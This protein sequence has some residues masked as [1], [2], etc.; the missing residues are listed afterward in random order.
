MKDDYF[1]IERKSRRL[2]LLLLGCAA[3]VGVLLAVTYFSSGSSDTESLSLEESEFK[4]WMAQH[5]KAYK[6]AEEF[7]HRFKIFKDNM[8][9]IHV[10]NRQ[11]N[12]YTLGATEF[13]D[14]NH[15]E[16][17][18]LMSRPLPQRLSRPSRSPTAAVIAESVDWRE[19]G[20]VTPVKNQKSCGSCW[21]F[22]TTG[23]VEGAHFIKTGE[24]VSL[25][26]QQLIDCSKD[27]GND[28]CG[29]GLM[30]YGFNY[31]IAEGLEA[32]DEYGYTASDGKCKYD[33]TKA[34]VFISD[35]VHVRANDQAL[36]EALNVGPVSVAI[37]ATQA[38]FQFYKS[39]VIQASACGARLNHG[40]LVVGYT[41]DYWIIKNSW[42]ALW[43]EQGFVRL[44][45]DTSIRPGA[46]GI[47]LDS[48]YPIA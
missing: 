41:P 22:S 26:E 42:G 25:S 7:L 36:A 5:N 38:V 4:N 47:L 8:A 21:S 33:A 18:A 29:G 35:Y 11:G 32:E 6:T 27:Y 15:E 13:A 2:P 3:L 1:P 39:G 10:H 28:G 12:T 40:V 17:E 20:A 14:M 9:Y 23:A 37:E 43:G 31:A 16:F 19:A 34:N 48:T 44:Q 30:E 24:L 46:C 45:R